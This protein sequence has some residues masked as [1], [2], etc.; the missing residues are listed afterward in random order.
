MESFDWAED[1]FF[2]DENWKATKDDQEREDK[3]R[4]QLLVD[5]SSNRISRR[6]IQK[7]A[8]L[9]ISELMELISSEEF[10]ATSTWY[11]PGDLCCF[12]PK[13]ME[14]KSK[15]TQVCDISGAL[16]QAGSLYYTYRPFLENLTRKRKFVLK[17]TIKAEIGYYDFF[18]KSLIEFENLACNL[19]SGS[20]QGEYDY[21]DLS[22]RIGETLPLKELKKR[23]GA[24]L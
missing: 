9:P 13:V 12:Y 21:Y 14:Y 15:S 8:S 20:C 22:K 2:F 16:I 10:S 6:V 23:K 4:E 11:F 1:I 5:L 24:K 7:N 19:A 17:R 3:L 18:P